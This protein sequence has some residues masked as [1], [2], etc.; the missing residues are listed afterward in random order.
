LRDL[1]RHCHLTPADVLDGH[2]F[3]EFYLVWCAG[4]T[5]K[6]HSPGAVRDKINRLRA[7][8]GLPPVTDT[9]KK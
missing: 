6:P 1:A 2:S 8:K 3:A 5:R 9:P 7:A 4:E